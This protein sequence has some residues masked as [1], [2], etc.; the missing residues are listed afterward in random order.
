MPRPYVT[1]AEYPMDMVRLACTKCERRGLYSKAT[2][3]EHFGP[4]KNMVE[5]RLELAAGCPKIAANKIMDLC[6]VYYPDRIG[7]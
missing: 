3:I 4:D 6:G 1:L 2:L 7:R 5:L